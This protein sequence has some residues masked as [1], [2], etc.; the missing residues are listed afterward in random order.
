MRAKL[1][2][3]LVAKNN[4]LVVV[5]KARPSRWK[6]TARG[7]HPAFDIATLADEV[8]GAVLMADALDILLDDRPFI[9][10]GP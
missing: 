6:A 8:F 10:I 5:S 7:Q 1:S 4:R 3:D 9:E 2:V